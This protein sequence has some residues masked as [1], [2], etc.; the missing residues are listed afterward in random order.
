MYLIMVYPWLNPWFYQN[1]LTG[2]FPSSHKCSRSNWSQHWKQISFPDE[3]K[4]L[5]G[6]S[7]PNDCSVSSKIF[8]VGAGRSDNTLV[9][10]LLML[11]CSALSMSE[12]E[13][14]D[15]VQLTPKWWP[16]AFIKAFK[17]CRLFFVFFHVINLSTSFSNCIMSTFTQKANISW[18]KQHCLDQLVCVWLVF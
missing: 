5:R 4:I 11:H 14:V 3:V 18:R 1:L 7:N 16:K 15:K 10:A 9:M 12:Y 2:L 8:R 6:L 13:R 17:H